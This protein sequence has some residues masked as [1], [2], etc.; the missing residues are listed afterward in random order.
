ML[1]AS[2]AIGIVAGWMWTPRPNAPARHWLAKL[3][4]ATLTLTALTFLTPLAPK[5]AIFGALAGLC[6]HAM[7]LGTL[8]ARRRTAK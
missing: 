1:A 2:V 6:A 4:F 8:W 3:F 5:A 7:F